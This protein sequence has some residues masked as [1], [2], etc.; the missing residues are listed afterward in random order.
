MA[1]AKNAVATKPATKTRNATAT[2]GTKT[3]RANLDTATKAVLAGKTNAETTAATAPPKPAKTNRQKTKDAGP[4]VNRTPVDLHRILQT[5]KLTDLFS[6]MTEDQS[7]QAERFFLNRRKARTI[8]ESEA[9]AAFVPN[10]PERAVLSGTVSALR[11]HLFTLVGKDASIHSNTAIAKAIDSLP[12]IA[13][14][15]AV[16]PNFVHMEPSMASL[17]RTCQRV[18][19]ILA[20][21]AKLQKTG[22]IS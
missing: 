4:V 6:A 1:N 21:E 15:D 8:A 10:K 11:D 13:L 3:K 9:R 20:D 19:S 22:R 7:R 5:V 12:F 17:K 14:T 2:K 16:D 18:V